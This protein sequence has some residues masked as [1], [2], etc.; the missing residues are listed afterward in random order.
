MWKP[1]R[2]VFGHGPPATVVIEILIADYVVGNIAA[3][4]CMIFTKVALVAPGIEI[5]FL[6]QRLDIGAQGIRAGEDTLLARMKSKSGAPAGNLAFAV[7]DVNYRGVSGF[8]DVDA[9]VAGTQ[10]GECKIG[11]VDFDGLVLF[12]TANTEIDGAFGETNLQ[13]AVIEVE[14]R[15]AGH[16]AEAN[17]GGADVQFRAGALIG[18]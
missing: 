9:V 8:I 6:C 15:K 2:A 11:G 13:R 17:R 10:D 14:E 3:R 1:H 16:F 4:D 7:A 12:Q 5:I 18:P